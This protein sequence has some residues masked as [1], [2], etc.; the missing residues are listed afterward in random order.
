MV[1]P[2]DL[3]VPA[4]EDEDLA[5]LAREVEDLVVP[6]ARRVDPVVADPVVPCD[7]AADPVVPCAREEGLAGPFFPRARWAISV[8]TPMAAATG[9]SINPATASAPRPP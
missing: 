1:E 8:P 7:D 6:A 2:T 4:R 3:V 9:H 5:V